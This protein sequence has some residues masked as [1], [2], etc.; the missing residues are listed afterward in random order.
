MHAGRCAGV[1]LHLE[2]ARGTVDP[3]V[4]LSYDSE[5]EARE[6][7]LNLYNLA[8]AFGAALI[9]LPARAPFIKEC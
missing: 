7:L 9:A 6:E 1:H 3:R 8:T 2:V 4:A 5:K